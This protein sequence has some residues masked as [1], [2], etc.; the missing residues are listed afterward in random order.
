M[1]FASPLGLLALL[2]IPAI[3]A[4]HLFRR[5]F[6][7]RP[8]AGLFLW[9][10]GR[11]TPEGGGKIS[12]LPITTSL[13]LECLAALALALILAGA[14]LSS[15]GVS[16]HL[17]V[18]LDDSASMAAANSRGESA[19]SRGVR[20]VLD[21]IDRLGNR[22]LV[23]IVQSG[24]RP[25]VL[26]G[27]TAPAIE[28]RRAL[29]NWQPE[30]PHH[31]LALG[32]RVARELAGRNSRLLVITDATPSA[33]P[34]D[35]ELWA[36]VGEPL[37]NVGIMAAD[38]TL[39]TGE[40]RATIALT[41][42]NYSTAAA[43]RAIT[44]SAADK[45]L[46]TRSLELPPGLSSLTLPLSPGLPAVRVALE[47]D[48][49]PRDN[50]VM[51][52]EPRP[53]VVGVATQLPEGRGRQ[54]VLRALASVAGVTQ[55]QDSPHLVV[56]DASDLDRAAPPGTWRAGFGRAPASWLAKG[57]PQDF[58]GPFVLEKRHPLLLGVS[59]GGVVWPGAMPLAGDVRPVASSGDHALIGMRSSGTPGN[60]PAILFNLDL[61]RTNLIRS[62]DWPILISNLV[63]M[64]RQALPG[65][66]RW[67]Y[68]VGEWVRVRLGR[69]PKGS[70]RIRS[71]PVE[72]PAFRSPKGEGG[73][74]REL[75]FIA[76]SP[77]GLLQII[78]DPDG[79]AGDAVL[80]ELGVNFLDETEAN[81]RD[82]SSGN[83]GQFADAPGLRAET[84]PASDP[85]FWV[86]LAIAGTALLAN[87]C[88]LT[89][90][91]GRA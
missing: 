24:V 37:S 12:R 65:P 55:Q 31:S 19:R 11:Q 75:E 7:V 52:V 42:G 33:P 13:M 64:R 73:P 17:V 49:L 32:L 27:P 44:V 6:P 1:I 25:S 59:F 45:V 20:R 9:Q 22:G 63:E 5:R 29:D 2:A 79:S 28:A 91:R 39:E 36:S 90:A 61:D 67:N 30:A 48:A 10:I 88:L 58:I 82:R 81:L 74:L 69:D 77:G 50:D 56:G 40:G 35:G 34:S 14:R 78:E 60:Q 72:R 46:L 70:L 18:L 83:A 43:R 16:P 62:P 51:L 4:I 3:V 47:N 23:T 8:V 66:E 76:P 38:R 87:W 85:L 84:G 71:G 54:A 21:E 80:Y 53:R 89:P 41:L 86:L 57:E 26:A 15:A 68:R